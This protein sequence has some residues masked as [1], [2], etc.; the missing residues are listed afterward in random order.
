MERVN[1]MDLDAARSVLLLACRRQPSFVFN[2]LEEDGGNAGGHPNPQPD[3]L[4]VPNWCQCSHCREMPPGEQLCCNQNP[5]NCYSRLPDFSTVVLDELVLEVAMRYRDDILRQPADAD[6]NRSHRH[7]AYR[8]FIL[9]IHGYLGAGNR[10]VIPSCCLWRIR[11]K[12]PDPLG[13]YVGFIAGRL[14]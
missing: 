2:L 10:R 4:V 1:A 7:A 8:Q 11:D 5:Q 12:Y 13:H 14:G 9:W 6:Y 3:V